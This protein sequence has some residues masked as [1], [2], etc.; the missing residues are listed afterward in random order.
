M[1]RL[2]IPADPTATIAL[3]KQKT[4]TLLTESSGC[5]LFSEFGTRR[6]R[7]FKIHDAVL[8]GLIAGDKEWAET[9]DG[10]RILAAN[11]GK[12]AGGLAGTSNASIQVAHGKVEN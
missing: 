12:K 4:L 6:R 9:E 7:S 10:K 8:Q 5:I 2:K 1:P 3:A 11:G